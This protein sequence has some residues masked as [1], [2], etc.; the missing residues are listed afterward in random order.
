MRDTRKAIIIFN[1]VLTDVFFYHNLLTKSDII[2][3]ADGGAEQAI[4]LGVNPDII[5]GDMDSISDDTYRKFE[6]AGTEFVIFPTNKDKTDGQL[7]IEYAIE[8]NY[9]D[10]IIIGWKGGRTDH[11][12]ANI[13]LLNIFSD[14][15][16]NLK[17]IAPKEEIFLLKGKTLFEFKTL[18]NYYVSFIP[19]ENCKNVKLTGFKYLLDNGELKLG[20]SLGISNEIL[21]EKSSIKMDNGVLIVIITGD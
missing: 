16:I 1:A 6:D 19:L 8:N 7:A 13:L 18:P 15:E 12:M 17:F 20:E 10:I 4:K 3:A 11:F 5:I 2:I 14:S 9:N 21:G